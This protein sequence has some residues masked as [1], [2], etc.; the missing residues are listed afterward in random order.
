MSMNL[1]TNSFASVVHRGTTLDFSGKSKPRERA[2]E[3]KYLL[4]YHG[5]GESALSRFV[6]LQRSG[7]M[8]ILSVLLGE[9]RFN[10]IT[11]DVVPMPSDAAG[12]ISPGCRLHSTAAMHVN[13]TTVPR[14]S[15]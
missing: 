11:F 6:A 7:R 13:Y 2:S 10:W 5:E 14:V 15:I 4:K 3:T 9:F 8:K 12:T 1:M